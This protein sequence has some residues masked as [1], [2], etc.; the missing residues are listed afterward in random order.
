MVEF[1]QSILDIIRHSGEARN[2]AI[3]AIAAAKE[4]DFEK[5]KDKLRQVD[6]LL[7][8]AHQKQTELIQLEASGVQIP[9]SLLLSHG[10]DHLMNAMMI[11]EMAYEFI[12]LYQR[13]ADNDR[14]N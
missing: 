5:A 11:K 10:Q 6:Q 1:E 13:L 4:D 2:Q 14:E 12:D 3:S 9:S 7:I 8:K